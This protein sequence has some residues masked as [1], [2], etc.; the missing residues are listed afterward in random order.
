MFLQWTFL[1]LFFLCTRIPSLLDNQQPPNMK[2]I[3]LILL[4][5]GVPSLAVRQPIQQ[6]KKINHAR[7]DLDSNFENGDDGLCPWVEESQGEV[8]WEIESYDSPWEPAWPAPQPPNGSHYLRVN[9]GDTLSFGI[10]I[11]R[12][13]NFTLVPG[14]NNSIS[15]SFSFWIKSKWPQFTNLEVWNTA[16]YNMQHKMYKM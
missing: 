13:P 4:L 7:V 3:F 12:S 8:H 14:F 1:L 9:R 16:I 11:L 15:F 2:D 6:C 10:A 5:S